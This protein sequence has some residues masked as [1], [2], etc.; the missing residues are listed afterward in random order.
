MNKRTLLAV[1]LATVDAGALS[2]LGITNA[3]AATALD[4][5][6]PPGGE[7]FNEPVPEAVNDGGRPATPTGGRTPK[8]VAVQKPNYP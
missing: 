8:A 3:S 2:A 1:A 6:L 4:P 7:A 5:A